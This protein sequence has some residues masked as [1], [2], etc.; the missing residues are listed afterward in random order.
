MKRFSPVL[1]FLAVAMAAAW[2]VTRGV[3]GVA[4]A[5]SVCLLVLLPALMAAQTR[6]IGDPREIPRTSI[7]F[8]S[9]ISLWLLAVVTAAVA[10]LS[11]LR[12]ANVGLFLVPLPQLLLWTTVCIVGGLMI[13]FAAR[14]LG[15][16]E[17]TITKH[18]L[19]VEPREKRVFSALSLSAGICEEFVFRG[20][21]FV[22]LYQAT[23][24]ATAATI[25]AAASFGVVHAYQQ[26]A[27]ALRATALGILLT[28]PVLATGSLVP[29]VLAHAALDLIAGLLLRKHW[30]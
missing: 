23:G 16:R 7:Y 15:L 10:W 3:P 26:L 28:A 2:T 12:P 24:S 6:W 8:S 14:A 19:P 20:F 30:S 18:L 22:A 29:A 4:R 11:G 17:T 27:G 21:L 25:L 9:L 1:L 13:V 5:W